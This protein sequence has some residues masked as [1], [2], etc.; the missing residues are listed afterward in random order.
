MVKYFFVFD[1]YKVNF[2]I[3][4]VDFYRPVV[5]KIIAEERTFVIN[6][7]NLFSLC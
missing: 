2:Y 3:C 5:Y 7:V 4:K 1:L 6:V